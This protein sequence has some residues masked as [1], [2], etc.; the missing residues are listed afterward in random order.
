MVLT[1][2]IAAAVVLS[3]RL[4]TTRREPAGW[5]PR[6]QHP[7]L[8]APAEDP[9]IA[10]SEPQVEHLLPQEAPLANLPLSPALRGQL[11]SLA[12]G[13][14]KRIVEAPSL[15]EHAAADGE[16]WPFVEAA[17]TRALNLASERQVQLAPLGRPRLT[18]A[19]A[20]CAAQGVLLAE[21]RQLDDGPTLWDGPAARIRASD[22]YVIYRLAEMMRRQLLPELFAGVH[23]QPPNF[24]IS[25]LVPYTIAQAFY[26][27]LRGAPPK[28]FAA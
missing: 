11:D 23:R 2:G 4:P 21:W 19:L 14:A 17:V 10:W 24:E 18:Q 12:L 25:L 6:V 26:L 20:H 7:E 9:L 28:A 3:R 8:P 16:S 27:R 15:L 1:V 5:R 13:R 22:T